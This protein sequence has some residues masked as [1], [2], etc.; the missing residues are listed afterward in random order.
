MPEEEKSHKEGLIEFYSSYRELFDFFCNNT[1]IHGAI[2][3]VCSQHNRMKTAFWVVLFLGTFGVMYW[4]F[5]LLFGQYFSYPVSINLNVNSD[6]LPFPAVTV[7]TLNPYRYSSIVG[8]LEE[9]DRVTE[10]TLFDLYKYNV[11]GVQ[12]R[13]PNSRRERRSGPPLPF[14][15]ERVYLGEGSHRERRSS[16]TG[17]REEEEM[18]VKRTDRNIGFKLCNETGGDCFYQTYSS[19]VDAI[20]EWYRFHY[21]NILAR[22]PQNGAINEQNLENFILACRFNEDSCIKTNYSHFHHAIYGNCYMFKQNVDSPANMWSSSMP[23]IK[24]GE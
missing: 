15:L 23:G 13:V 20:R 17:V 16:R 6:R 8:D 1:T 10:Q 14:P 24:N 18:Q 11:T 2:R 4:Q 7:C 12:G 5:G 19:G 22:V 21:I 9:L 3:M